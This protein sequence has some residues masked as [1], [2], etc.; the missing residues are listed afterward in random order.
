MRAR[1]WAAREW[2][3]AHDHDAMFAGSDMGAQKA[4]WQEAFAAEAANVGGVEHAQALLDPAKAFE[5]VPH[6]VLVKG[7]PRLLLGALAQAQLS[8]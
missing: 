3:R 2:G 5:T 6:W 1:I 8:E 4:S 7:V